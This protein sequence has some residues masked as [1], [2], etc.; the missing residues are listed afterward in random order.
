MIDDP[1]SFER[2]KDIQ[3][4]MKSDPLSHSQLLNA[5]IEFYGHYGDVDT[6]VHLFDQIHINNHDI[7]SIVTMLKVYSM[8]DHHQNVIDL[9][10]RIY[11]QL[12][13]S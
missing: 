1:L 10:D 4:V 9:Y 13:S 2:G 8:N 12:R 11:D 5:L 7:T 3:S 6:A